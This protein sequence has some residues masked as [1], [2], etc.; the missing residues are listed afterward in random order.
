MSDFVID[1]IVLIPDH[2][3][4]LEKRLKARPSHLEG[5]K[6]RIESDMWVMGGATVSAPPVEG[7]QK[8][9]NGSC[10]VARARSRDEV[11]EELRKDI[12]ARE[13]V[14]NLEKAQIL[15]VILS[16]NECFV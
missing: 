2:E 13:G 10:V 12:Y 14:W 5:L 6:P 11:L 1:W 16:V 4:A 8:Q 7:Q 9:F 15:P 3:N